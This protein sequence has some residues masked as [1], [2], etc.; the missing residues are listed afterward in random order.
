MKRLFDGIA[1]FLGLILL[2][3]LLLFLAILTRLF[4][5]TS[6]FVIQQGPGL[7]G[8]AF[9]MNKFCTVT[10][11][12][13]EAGNLL[14]DE[15]RL[16]P[17]GKFLRSS[18]LDEMTELIS[19]LKGEMSLVVPRPLLMEYLLVY[20]TERARR[21]EVKPGTIGWA[22]MN[23]R[24]FVSWEEKFRLDVWYVD[25]WS[26]WLDLKILYLTC[27]KVFRRAGINQAGHATISFDWT[28]P[29]TMQ[30]GFQATGEWYR[31]TYG[32]V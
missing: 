1:S 27:V 4:I 10:D 31:K 19:V 25:N 9:L 11:A 5:S 21:H 8:K 6:V 15:K 29:F 32:G 12:P 18:S 14:P 3:P 22:Q 30:E 13:D 16:T 7:H 24:N 2:D 26:F 20:K 28:P 17:F 23:G